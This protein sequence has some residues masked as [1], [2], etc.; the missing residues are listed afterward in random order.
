MVQRVAVIGAGLSGLSSIKT[1]LEEG[2]QPTC[3]E[4]SHDIGGLWRYKEE[5]EP[6]RANIYQSVIINSSKEMIAFSDFPPP[7]ELPNFMTHSELLG[8]LRLYADH[9]K[10]LRHIQFKTTVVKVRQTPGF[11]ETGQWEVDTEKQD[12]EKET[13]VFDAVIVCTGHYT[14]PHLPLQDFPGIADFAGR[15]FHSWDYRNSEGLQGKKVVVIGIG[16]SGGDIAVDISRVAEQVYLSTRSG[17]WV[18]SRVAQGGLPLDVSLVSRLR[19]L[20]ATLFPS[21]FNKTLE[22]KL[23]EQFDHSLYGLKPKHKF[24]S[25]IPLVNDELPARIISG[26]V[27]IKPNVKEFSGS[28]VVFEDGSVLDQV[29][30]VVFATGYNYS[31]P[32]LPA[33]LQSKSGYRLRLFKHIFPPTLA[34][35]TLAVVGFI[36][37]FGSINTTAEMQGRCATRVF[38]G[39]IKLPSKEKMMKE[40]E[41]DT[42]VMH[43]W[44]SCT[45][46]N[47]LHV[48]YVTYMDSLAEQVGV[49]PNLLWLFLTDPRL[50]V[51]VL[52]GPLTPY[53]FRLSGPGRWSGARQAILTQWD[54]VL[55]PFKTRVVPEPEKRPVSK[56]KISV[57][58]SG[59]ALMCFL[60]YKQQ[61]LPK[62]SIM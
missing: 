6:G 62:L 37:G 8:Y 24:F 21:W 61:P 12:G 35:P 56:L 2:L 5:P 10:L 16:N 31:F 45:E 20:L 60:L 42:E 40:I 18:V 55:Q 51:Q 43:R 26:R 48:N 7:A 28:S 53:Q 50:A 4:S 1:C 9:F 44:F 34:R 38:K 25:Q 19:E 39:I 23:N 41:Q 59:T 30:V 32:I 22:R 49:R 47:P 27:R 57:I 54:R 33:E 29:D 58:V 11:A 14:R 46:R 52:A 15:Y 3:F 13:Q 17:A 36:S